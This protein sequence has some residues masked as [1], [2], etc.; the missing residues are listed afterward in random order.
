MEGY[1]AHTDSRVADDRTEAVGGM[2]NEI[3]ELQFQFLKRVGLKPEHRMLDIGCGTLR[4]G[5]FSIRFL[6]VSNYTGIDISPACIDAAKRLVEEENL[7][8]KQ[9]KLILNESKAMNFDDLEDENFDYILAQ[10]V[11]THF[12]SDVPKRLS[13]KDFSYPWTFFEELAE[14]NGFDSEEVS[15][16]YDHP[17]D[18]KMGVIRKTSQ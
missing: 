12:Q 13:I 8:D 11:F 3:G 16:F 9:P 17:R 5:R 10:S 15:H 4:G 14:E 18:Q 6:G 1:A 7:K 2:W